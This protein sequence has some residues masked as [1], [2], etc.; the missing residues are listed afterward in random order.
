M[1]ATVEEKLALRD[2]ADR[3]A[4]AVDTKDSAA[5]TALFWPEG[6]I[7]TYSTTEPDTASGRLEGHDA[8]AGIRQRMIDRYDRTFHLVSGAVHEVDGDEATGQVYCTAHHLKRYPDGE[9][10][11]RVMFIHYQDRYARRDGQWRIVER[12]LR[13]PWIERRTLDER[14]QLGPPHTGD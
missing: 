13:V 3:Y 10:V 4:L 11:D 12:V 2:L 6:T 1:T 8:I 5:L 9:I 14:S 7:V